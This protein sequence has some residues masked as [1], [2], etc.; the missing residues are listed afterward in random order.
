MI[1]VAGRSSRGAAPASM[2]LQVHDELLLEVPEA[3]VEPTKKLVAEAMEVAAS[4]A[5]PWSST[6]A[7]AATGTRRIEDGRARRLLR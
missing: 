1:R 7:P 4:L 5:S 6:P 2:L 3:E